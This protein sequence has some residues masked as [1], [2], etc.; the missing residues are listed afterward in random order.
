VNS[1][2]EW[3]DLMS[4]WQSQSVDV[5]KLK[6]STRWKT[7]RMAL[8]TA[9]EILLTLFVWATL[10]QSWEAFADKPLLR[11][12]MLGW[13]V[14][15]PLMGWWAFRLRR[16]QWRAADE[17]VLAL[18]RLRLDRARG[19][20]RMAR[21][22]LW[23]CAFMAVVTGPWLVVM[24]FGSHLPPGTPSHK[25]WGAALFV[26]VWLLAFIIASLVY[27]RQRRREVTELELLLGKLDATP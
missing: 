21:F 15:T 6:R 8:M 9:S 14:L 13:S 27:L 17:S 24:H 1:N 5:P 23:T 12:W 18:L 16:G 3:R 11:G 25:A 7:C 26:T 20:I 2:E 19:G 22:T 4:A 10:L